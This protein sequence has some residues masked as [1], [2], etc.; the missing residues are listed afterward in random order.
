MKY[1]LIGEHLGHSFS[2][3]IHESFADY[4]YEIKE[5]SPEKVESFFEERNFKG[6]NV[7]IP[8]KTSIIPL[9]DEVSKEAK[10]IGAVNTVVNQ[11]GK[12][13]GYNTDFF[14]LKSLL[15]ANE[16]EVKG[17]KV[18]ILGTGGTSKTAFA[19]VE[20]LG[21]ASIQKVSRNPKENEISYEQAKKKQDTN[22]I[23]N[24]TPC[25]M[26]PNNEQSPISLESFKELSAV[27]D[28][29]YNPL[30]SNL[31]L[32]AKEKGIIACGGLHMLVAQ[33]VAASELFCNKK[34]L[35]ETVRKTYKKIFSNK[36]NVVLIGMPGC[37]KTTFGKLLAEKM[38]R[39]FIDLD[40]FIA[41]MF[42]KT[43][44]QIIENE[45]ENAFRQKESEAVKKVALLQGVVISTGGGTV[46]RKENV[47][48]LKQNGKT[49]FLD[50]PIEEIV[51][52]GDRPLSSSREALE[53][54]YKERLPIYLGAGQIHLDYTGD[55]ELNV[56]KLWGKL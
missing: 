52:T 35:Q 46:L 47:N 1:G 19:V 4:E 18:L 7:T 27:V 2:K 25:G 6:I 37:G 21:A 3:E 5:L 49:V 42:G 29:I 24:T 16:I 13:Y 45:G 28:V 8:Y 11:N 34:F 38:H 15:K 9:L 26:F 50:R 54:R 36:Q 17:K 44:K 51:P 55:I 14:G 12:L 10:Q 22:I 40:Y 53:K 43:P 31:I 48:L 39:Q 41:E 32:S 33:A 23:I 20:S 56:E 30:Y